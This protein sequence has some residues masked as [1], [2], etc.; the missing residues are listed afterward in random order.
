[1]TNNPP[2]LDYAVRPL[3]VLHHLA[4]DE[5]DGCARLQFPVASKMAR[6]TTL[7][8]VLAG[9][10]FTLVFAGLVAESMW[11]L[12]PERRTG[13]WDGLMP[14]LLSAMAIGC[15]LAALAAVEWRKYHQFS[16]IPRTLLASA[17]G[18]TW[19]RLGRWGMRERHWPAAEI[20][21]VEL[22]PVRT[23]L[24]R[25]I[26]ATLYF[27]RHNASSLRYRLSSAD[28]TLLD[29]IPNTFAAA[30]GCPVV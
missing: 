17:S 10:A 12:N 11:T 29:R 7:L 16:H 26:R 30:L 14:F 22:R 8:S 28:S 27:H 6:I 24:T 9:L 15:V 21:A 3:A 23:L 1:M 2:Q 13:N 20:S 4:L 25:R 18:L 5:L 19:S